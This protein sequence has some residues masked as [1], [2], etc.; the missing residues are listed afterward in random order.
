MDI[1]KY[2]TEEA[3][4]A[5]EFVTKIRLLISRIWPDALINVKFNVS[6][7]PSI[8]IWFASTS[9]KNMWPMRIV[10]NDPCYNIIFIYG[11]DRDGN[12]G[13]N[14]ELKGSQV[15]CRDRKTWKRDKC[16][17]RDVKKGNVTKILSALEKYFKKM[18]EVF[19]AAE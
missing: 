2:L 4:D 15:G 3:S 9:N 12:M 8:T 6:I 10:E 1:R 14:L 7:Y 16:G 19:D 13:E 5:Q 18:K 11:F 17:W